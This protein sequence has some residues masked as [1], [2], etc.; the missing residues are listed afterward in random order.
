MRDW[1]SKRDSCKAERL[2]KELSNGLVKGTRV[3]EVDTS[4]QRATESSLK[5][6]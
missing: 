5:G 2:L 3:K 1:A 6:C 4:S